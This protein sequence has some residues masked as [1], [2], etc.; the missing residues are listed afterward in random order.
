MCNGRS[1]SLAHRLFHVCCHCFHE[2][3][4]L[5]KYLILQRNCPV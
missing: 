3:I 1:I 4:L 2:E 5:H